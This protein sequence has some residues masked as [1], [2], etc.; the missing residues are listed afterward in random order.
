LVEDKKAM[1]VLDKILKTFKEYNIKAGGTLE[2]KLLMQ[3]I[4]KLSPSE[5]SQVRD[6]WHILVGNGL[7]EERS[8]IGPTLT[9]LGEEMVYSEK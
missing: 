1:E 4:A 5:K 7:I 9:E 8:P 3:E 6:A 2:K